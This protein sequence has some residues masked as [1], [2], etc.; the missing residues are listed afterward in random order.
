LRHA[1]PDL[2]TSKGAEA[3]LACIPLYGT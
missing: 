3:R 1:L 2:R